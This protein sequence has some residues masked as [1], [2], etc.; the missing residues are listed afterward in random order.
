VVDD[1]DIQ[2]SEQQHQSNII[3]NITEWST[4]IVDKNGN[5]YTPVDDS[6][7]EYATV[8]DHEG[9]EYDLDNLD[10]YSIL[11]RFDGNIILDDYE[12]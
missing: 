12:V 6:G 11:H 3:D 2:Q 1:D 8:I 7:E 10:D 4:I 9:N 5:E